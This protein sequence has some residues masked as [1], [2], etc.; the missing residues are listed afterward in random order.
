MKWTPIFFAQLAD[1]PVVADN[2]FGMVLQGGSF[3]LIAV[4]V[5]TACY[6]VVFKWPDYRKEIREDHE[7]EA[8][9]IADERQKDR[10]ARHVAANQQSALVADIIAGNKQTVE[11]IRAMAHQQ[12]EQMRA[13]H[14]EDV[15]A[16]TSA[17]TDQTKE[18]RHAIL[19]GQKG[20]D[21]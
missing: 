2:W 9:R 11:Q 15:H 3:A 18:L 19:Y 1:K 20:R 13:M 21:E 16:I 10:D 7:K 6:W 14:R 12:I 8:Q 17:I 5:L 4:M